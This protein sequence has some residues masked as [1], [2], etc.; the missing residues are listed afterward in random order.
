MSF[1]PIS[2]ASGSLSPQAF[3]ARGGLSPLDAATKGLRMGELQ[4]IL[5]P[6]F[7]GK[8]SE[9]MRRARRYAL[10]SSRVLMVKYHK[11]TRYSE[12][13]VSSHDRVIMEAVS[14][15][16]L[17]GLLET[18]VDYDVIGIDEG[19]FFPD[20]LE[21]CDKA[22]DMGKIVIVAALDADFKRRPFGRVCE[23][24]PMAE[25]VVKLTA[26][27]GICKCAEASFTKRLGNE[28]AV[29]I[30]GGADMYKPCCRACYN[31]GTEELQ[32]RIQSPV[33]K[34]MSAAA[35]ASQMP[36]PSGISTLAQ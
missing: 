1:R 35:P 3:I 36:T 34:A 29:E 9:L 16:D 17:M 18:V 6:M 22:A 4:L 2:P 12:N 19:Q 28:K 26:V 15:A 23:L 7:A 32:S 30:I 11:D 21:F 8:S 5:G 14:C 24:V 20:L 13:C 33:P 27:C 25:S 31:K 10:A